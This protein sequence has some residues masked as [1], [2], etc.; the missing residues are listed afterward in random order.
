MAPE[1]RALWRGPVVHAVLCIGVAA[2]LF[3]AHAPNTAQ[4][5]QP[6]A[7]APTAL[8]PEDASVTHVTLTG[9]DGRVRTRVDRVKPGGQA[10]P[11]V[12]A[13]NPVSGETYAF[14][15]N[16]RASRVLDKAAPLVPQRLLGTPSAAALADMGLTPIRDQLV[17]HTADGAHTTLTLGKAQHGSDTVYAQLPAGPGLHAGQ[18]VLLAGTFARGLRSPWLRLPRL[19]VFGMDID[20]CTNVE[21]TTPDGLGSAATR[22]WR[23]ERVDGSWVTTARP[24]VPAAGATPTAQISTARA[25]VTALFGLRGQQALPDAVLARAKATRQAVLHARLTCAASG[26]APAPFELTVYR[27]PATPGGHHTYTAR[28]PHLGRAQRIS[29]GPTDTLLRRLGAPVPR[30]ADDGPAQLVPPRL[31]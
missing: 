15:G 22:V 10:G 2:G 21:L 23:L 29:R 28:S 18:V 11:W 6:G 8:V 3:A 9:P 17:V 19:D 25:L 24:T 31:P 7:D 5:T 26:K 14:M 1:Q 16:A 30:G 13:T 20:T 12:T 27:H 4:P